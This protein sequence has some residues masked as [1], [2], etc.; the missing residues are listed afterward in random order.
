MEKKTFYI[1]LIT[2]L[3]SVCYNTVPLSNKRDKILR[4]QWAQWYGY[5]PFRV[6]FL[7]QSA[8]LFSSRET[9]ENEKFGLEIQILLILYLIELIS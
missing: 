8:I 7:T 9:K 4:G 1:L 2:R 5:Y 6:Y 3:Q